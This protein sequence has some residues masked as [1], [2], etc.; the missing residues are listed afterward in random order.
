MNISEIVELLYESNF[1]RFFRAPKKFIAE[2]GLQNNVDST[3]MMVF[4]VSGYLQPWKKTAW[5]FNV[6]KWKRPLLR[7][8]L[9]FH[10]LRY[11]AL[12]ESIYDRHAAISMSV[13]PVFIVWGM[14]QPDDLTEYAE[15]F[16]IPIVR[17]EDGFFRSMGLGSEHNPP[18]SLCIDKTGIYFDSSKPSDLESILAN[19]DFSKDSR[20]MDEARACLSEI[21]THGLSK[22]NEVIPPK[23]HLL[24]GPK[25]KTRI[26]VIGQVEDDQSL[27]FGCN[28]IMNNVDLIRLVAQENPD[29]Q[30]IYKA[31]PD[32]LAGKRN[33]ISNPQDV[34]ELAE[35]F[36]TSLTLKDALYEVDRVYT[37]T[38]LA[39][40][41][42]LIH[43]V[44]V[45]T[46]GAPFYSG[47]GLTDDRQ[48][49]ARR[50]RKLSLEELF[51]GAYL[52]YPKYYDP[53]LRR[54]SSLLDV[55]EL[56]KERLSEIKFVTP[57]RALDRLRPFNFATRNAV[58]ARYIYNSAAESVA[59]VT[60]TSESLVVAR[61]F[62]ARGKKVTLLSTRDA[63]AN[64]DE[65]LLTFEESKN[66]SISS[67]HKRYSVAL[68]EIEA[69]SVALAKTFSL[70]ISYVI[71]RVFGKNI[72]MSVVDALMMGL[73]DHIYFEALRYHAAK[74]CLEQFDSVLLIFDNYESNV[75]V[76]KSF[77]YHAEVTKKLGRVYLRALNDNT[78][79]I[80]YKLFEAQKLKEPNQ[81]EESVL[82]DDFNSFWFDLQDERYDDY[83]GLQGYIAVC[84]NVARDNYAYLPASMKLVEILARNSKNPL[85]FYSTALM[86][87]QSQD[88]VKTVTL[89]EQLSAHCT[90]YNGCLAKYR[91][92]YPQQTLEAT[93]MFS[94]RVADWVFATSSKRLP[95]LFI[96][97]FRPRLEKFIQGLF[98][99]TIF[100]A[101]SM[102]IMKRCKLV[103]TSMD[104][105]MVSRI[106]TAI[107]DIN[108]VPTIGIQPQIISASPRYMRP[109]VQRMGVID[110]AQV[111]V[112][113]MLGAN[114]S[115]LSV[116]GSVNILNRLLQIAECESEASEPPN[117]RRILFAMQHSNPNDM[118]WTANA[119]RDIS[120]K[121][122]FEIIVKPHPH[123][124]LPVLH[125]VRRIFSQSNNVAVLA[126]TADTYKAAATCGIVVGLFSSVLL[127][128]A[129]SGKPV[130]IAAYNDLH[131]TIDFSLRGLA[132][133]ALTYDEL[134]SLL[135][136]ILH[137]GSK[138]NALQNSVQDYLR[139]NPQFEKP[140]SDAL[141]DQ[142][143]ESALST[144]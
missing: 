44:P 8:Y 80:I 101:E 18:Y 40:F 65:M 48:I 46:I 140:Y 59:I 34:A 58:S 15:E 143:I 126:R 45:T 12:K 30:I 23:A 98:T 121:H 31:H 77:A 84:G 142:F 90:V 135:L 108:E 85:L 21:R 36:E 66:I 63:L 103:A 110:D 129:I 37:L 104:R 107:A 10:R 54:R 137:K 7:R 81:V 49:T 128:A 27:L 122:G 123:Q 76:V 119:L 5:A 64:T 113:E 86:S 141:I 20:L 38:S 97:I 118:L 6:A 53:E 114:R 11:M 78:K 95:Y 75:D 127:E 138:F 19:Y 25:V 70:D 50:T 115:A 13:N 133:K 130:V 125:E 3:R 74:V 94:E 51:A 68:S 24:Y 96:D 35:I 93:L 111:D 73:E 82:V 9:P 124:E 57:D 26:L 105:S 71:N 55:I 41:E 91:D 22:Y 131:P 4:A 67:L 134:E 100:I 47:W 87:A 60:D 61:G 79:E 120:A 69:N 112:Y 33:E 89:L 17:L 28:Q 39:G 16:N 144:I 106:L 117:L 136:D 29:A 99:Q 42:A 14:I 92:K 139:R 52:L 1:A 88:E 132:L 56:F 62:A 32:I 2:S 72:P 109:A 43:G 116:I 102:R 83:A